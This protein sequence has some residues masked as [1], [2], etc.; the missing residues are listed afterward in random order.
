LELNLRDIRLSHGF[1]LKLQKAIADGRLKYE[2]D[3]ETIIDRL[4]QELLYYNGK[5]WVSEPAESSH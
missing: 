2:M 3:D 1:Q 5:D 4:K